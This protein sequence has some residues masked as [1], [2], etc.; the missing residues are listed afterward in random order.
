MLVWK[1]MASIRPMMSP[2][3]WLDW[4]MLCMLCTA[5]VT[6]APP[7][8]A[9]CEAV[10]TSWWA[11]WAEVAEC[12]TWSLSVAIDDTVCCTL[13]AV[14]SVRLERSWL[15]LAISRLAVAMFSLASRTCDTMPDNPPR[16]LSSARCRSATSSRPCTA[17]WRERSP[18]AMAWASSRASSMGWQIACML[19]SVSGATTSTVSTSRPAKISRVCCST[20]PWRASASRACSRNCASSSLSSLSAA[21]ACSPARAAMRLAMVAVS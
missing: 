21:S 14:C 20:A 16:M 17:I 5:C 6:T 4:A 8:C 2:I 9:A 19:S 7:R 15:P 18:L 1:A 10:P 11:V 12:C 13:P 3:L